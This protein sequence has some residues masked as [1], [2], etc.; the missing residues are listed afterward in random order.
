MI[1]HTYTPLDNLVDAVMIAAFKVHDISETSAI[2]AGRL[3]IKNLIADFID[4]TIMGK[5]L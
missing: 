4:R 1:G 2:T 5:Q 3:E